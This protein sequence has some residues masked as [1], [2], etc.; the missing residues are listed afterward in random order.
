MNLL[1]FDIET[2]GKYKDFQTFKDLDLRGANLF[3][4]KANK[5]RWLEID[6]IEEA[7][8]NKSPLHPEFNVIVCLTYGYEDSREGF[9][10]KSFTGDEKEILK[11]SNKIWTNF[12]K[13]N[14]I[15]CGYNI[16]RFDLPLLNIKHYQHNVPMH[17]ILDIKDKKPWDI[18]HADIFEKWNHGFN[19]FVSLDEVCYVL[20]IESPK[21]NMKGSDVH[22]E[23]YAGNIDRIVKYCEGDVKV[24]PQIIEKMY[25][26]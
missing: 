8:L 16:K 10:V 6:T 25:Y 23:F 17:N 13:K 24:L 21:D 14:Y 26:I 3:E 7:Y 20:G 19:S 2:A 4:K 15:G 18:Q 12:I 9:R 5:H 1:Y 11:N 22:K